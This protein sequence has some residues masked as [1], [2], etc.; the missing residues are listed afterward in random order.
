MG[1]TWK[2][3]LRRLA[4]FCAWVILGLGVLVLLQALTGC[5]GPGHTFEEQVAAL[6][7]GAQGVAVVAGQHWAVPVIG[8]LGALAT[9]VY[10]VAV[11]VPGVKAVPGTRAHRKRA[12]KKAQREAAASPTPPDRP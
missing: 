5:L 2:E 6:A 9:A 7:K 12:V 8:G 1:T 4:H 10:H 11:G 3:E